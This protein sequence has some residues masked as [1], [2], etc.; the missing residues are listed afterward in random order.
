MDAIVLSV[1]A[2]GRF[3]DE[4]FYNFCQDNPTLRF[5]RDALGHIIIIPNTGEHQSHQF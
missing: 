4:E 1:N 2:V 3:N 5:E